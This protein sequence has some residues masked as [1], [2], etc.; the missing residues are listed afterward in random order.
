MKSASDLLFKAAQARKLAALCAD[1]RA[2]AALL[3][4]AL[5]LEA[6]AKKLLENPPSNPEREPE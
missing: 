4:R 6:A 2:E 5:D 1:A 3:Q